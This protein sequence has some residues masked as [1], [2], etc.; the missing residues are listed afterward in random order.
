MKR[1]RGIFLTLDVVVAMML[2]FMVVML[3]FAYYSS[4]SQQAPAFSTQLLQSYAQ[5]AAT[6]LVSKGY[7]SAPLDS[8][9][10][11]NTSGIREVLA[12]TPPS[13]CMQVEAHGAITGGKIGGST[14]LSDGLIGYWKLNEG[15]GPTAADYSGNGFT[16]VLRGGGT[17]FV[18]T[19]ASGGAA[20]FDGRYGSSSEGYVEVAHD[21]RLE[22]PSI[23]VAVWVKLPGNDGTYSYPLIKWAGYAMKISSDARPYWRI[24]GYKD[25]YS[26]T[27]WRAIPFNQWALLVGTFDNATQ[28]ASFYINGEFTSSTVHGDNLGD[29]STLNDTIQY[30]ETYPLTISAD[31]RWGANTMNGSTDE[32]RIY[33]RALT[34][35]EVRELYSNPGNL[36]YVVD[37]PGCTYSGGEIQSLT[38]P[39]AHNGNQNGNN[40]YYAVLKTWLKGGRP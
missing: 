27:D 32:V 2:L 22:P 17:R 38:A 3:A 16:G 6:V 20:Y 37:K 34:Q 26:I 19:G 7:L 12:A 9:N 23:S 4:S 5:D 40:Y 1:T 11:S 29:S 13:V 10:N 39:F 25:L 18:E 8:L 31:S 30:G 14:S 33:N 24:T 28:N 15:A 35:A 36:L 21:S